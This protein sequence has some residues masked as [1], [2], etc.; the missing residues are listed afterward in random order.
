LWYGF[1]NESDLNN[2]EN[3]NTEI[4]TVGFWL[5][6]GILSIPLVFVWLL[7]RKGHSVTSRIVGFSWLFVCFIPMLASG[8]NSK[9]NKTIDKP[10]VVESVRENPP[11]EEKPIDYNSYFGE[12]I[13]DIKSSV[14]FFKSSFKDSTNSLDVGAVSFSIWA[15]KKDISWKDLNSLTKT[16]YAKCKKDID[17]ERGNVLCVSGSVLEM[18]VQRS[19]YGAV[20]VGGFNSSSFNIVRFIAVK[21]T[22]ELV[23]GSESKLCGV[24]TGLQ[25]YSNSGGGTTHAV[26]VVG[27]F[28]LPEN[29]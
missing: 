26:H 3:N 20:Y 27:L 25:S 5:G 10:T 12:N 8:G 24:V 2:M 13:N 22:G 4:R 17:S 21:S 9:N 19:G 29:K 15:M 18:T 14:D 28:D 6:V 11:P 23:N 16:S 7:L 1:I